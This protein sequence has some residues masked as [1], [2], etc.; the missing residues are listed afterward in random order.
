MRFPFITARRERR[1]MQD[2]ALRALTESGIQVHR[3]I[4]HLDKH[5]Q[6]IGRL[7]QR[8]ELLVIAAH[9][10]AEKFTDPALAASLADQLSD[11]ELEPL[12]D[13]FH[14]AGRPEAADVWHFHHSSDASDF[15]DEDDPMGV[16]GVMKSVMK[17]SVEPDYACPHGCG[18][19]AT[20]ARYVNEHL[21][22][23]HADDQDQADA[24]HA[25]YLETGNPF[26]T[27]A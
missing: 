3:S 23:A 16:M 8:R 25:L 24:D 12:L 21:N 10:L 19:E 7:S 14:A 11:A 13:L 15:D 20:D 27:T 18:F 17:P 1:A 4:E 6:E 2:N 26:I 22:E 9:A 5:V